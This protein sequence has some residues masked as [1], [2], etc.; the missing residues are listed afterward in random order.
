MFPELFRLPFGSKGLVIPTY[1]IF[2]LIAI[3]CS[4][5]ILILRL[6]KE[7]ISTDGSLAVGGVAIGLGFAGGLL[8]GFLF[9]LFDMVHPDTSVLLTGSVT[10][11]GGII[12]GLAGGSWVLNQYG[13]DVVRSL[14][15][16]IPAVFLGLGIGR[17]GCFFGGCCF[18]TPTQ[19]P[20]G[21]I[22][23]PGHPSRALFANVAIHPTPIY[24]SLVA[25][26]IFLFGFK[27]SLKSSNGTTL[28]VSIGLYSIFRFG[29]EFLRGDHFPALGGLSI[30]QIVAILM[31]F[32][33]YI[34][35][36]YNKHRSIQE[37]QSNAVN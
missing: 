32:G 4:W 26:G 37:N 34:Y 10:W 7:G 22:Y 31:L 30:Q 14:D 33:A 5:F 28:A 15:R 16:S 24:E 29:L 36:R 35:W 6:R 21:I 2:A 12:F 19:L 18:G 9:R 20:W 27:M 23:P 11:Q 3:A 1:G 13:V 25:L 8:T 17:I